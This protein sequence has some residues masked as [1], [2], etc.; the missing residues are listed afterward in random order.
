MYFVMY[1]S[2]VQAKVPKII[3]PIKQNFENSI[4]DYKIDYFDNTGVKMATIFNILDNTTELRM[5]K[6]LIGE[7]FSSGGATLYKNPSDQ[8]VYFA[9]FCVHFILHIFVFDFPLSSQYYRFP[10]VIVL[11]V[12]Y[13]YYICTTTHIVCDEILI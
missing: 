5:T 6:Y 7:I 3:V 12:F 13:Q 11:L 8:T 9:F 4:F 10:I 1:N 2:K